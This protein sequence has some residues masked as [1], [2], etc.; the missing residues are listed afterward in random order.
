MDQ[1][2]EC[3]KMLQ[4][5]SAGKVPYTHTSI[6]SVILHFNP[7]LRAGD[8]ATSDHFESEFECPMQETH[9]GCIKSNVILHLAFQWH[10]NLSFAA[11]ERNTGS[12]YKIMMMAKKV[13]PSK[14]IILSECSKNVITLSERY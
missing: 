2:A 9:Y 8:L 3:W 11:I 5:T 13:F 10:K 6:S 7:L 12:D 4:I 14:H 1:L